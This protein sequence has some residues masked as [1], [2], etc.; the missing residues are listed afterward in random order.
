[1]YFII[2]YGHDV[3]SIQTPIDIHN[4]GNKKD[5]SEWYLTI[6]NFAKSV[7]YVETMSSLVKDM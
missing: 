2:L 1:M 5:W 3:V 7:K 6:L 4:Q